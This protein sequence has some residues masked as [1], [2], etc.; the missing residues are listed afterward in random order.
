M[1][2]VEHGSILENA[3]ERT[4]L[5]DHEGKSGAGLERVLLADG[6][7]LV[8]KRFSPSTD[9]LMAA[10][11]D[12]IGR[13][14]QLW[15][16]GVLDRLPPQVAHAVVD[17]WVEPEATVLVMSDLGDTVLRWVDRLSRERCRWVLAGVT[18]MHRSFLGKAPADLTP[19]SELIGIFSPTRLAPYA[20]GTNPLAAIA[21]RGWEIFAETVPDEVAGPVLALLADPGPLVAALQRRPTTLI[22]GDLATVNMAISRTASGDGQL[23][24]LDWSLPAEAPGAVDLARFVAGC[25][26]VVDAT[27]EEIVVDFR[28]ASGPAYDEPALRLAMLSGLVWLGWNKALDAA[29][30]ADLAI[31]AREQEDLDWWLRQAR[32]TLEAGLL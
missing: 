27:R 12:Q 23:T 11:G 2:V 21:I 10:T 32:L 1:T 29:E 9:L 18:A 17:G 3:V 14:Y 30:H 5:V 8:V 31:R 25:S 28:E 16:D 13:E 6:R 24:V 26:S 19:L 22:H 7:R 4:A 20:G 15:S